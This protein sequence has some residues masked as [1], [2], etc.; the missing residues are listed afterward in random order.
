MVASSSAIGAV[1][2]LMLSEARR[3]SDS[4]NTFAS[5]PA[6]NNVERDPTLRPTKA[7]TA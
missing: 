7:G 2:D 1:T 4:A 6:A 5:M 3:M